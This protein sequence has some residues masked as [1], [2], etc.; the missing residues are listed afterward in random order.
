MDKNEILLKQYLTHCKVYIKGI[1][2]MFLIGIVF[3]PVNAGP[4]NIAHMAKVTAS[5][6]LSDEYGPQKVTDGLINI[7][8][9]GE[10][11]S[12]NVTHPWAANV[13]RPWIKLD[14][15]HP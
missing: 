12:K 6:S 11:I 3:A 8:N 1:L 14:W 5:S 15:D 13:N 9:K 2:L 4:D 10:W 7:P